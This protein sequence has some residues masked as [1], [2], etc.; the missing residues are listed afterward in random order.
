MNSGR[1]SVE[2]GYKHEGVA[3]E[4]SPE[5]RLDG[6]NRGGKTLVVYYSRS[7]NTRM[8]A[9]AISKRLGCDL[10]EITEPKNRGGLLGYMGAGSEGRKESI[11][12]INPTKRDLANYNIVIVGTP[13]WAWN[14]SSPIRSYLTLN[15]GKFP[16][17][18]FYVTLDGRPGDS[19]K[20]METLVGKTPLTSELFYSSEI[21][22]G[23]IQD[24]V[25][26]FSDKILTHVSQELKGIV[27][28]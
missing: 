28:R 5:E 18:A 22:K 4:Q 2:N 1:T 24:K 3:F 21:K 19:L 25:E 8:V 13:I 6:T 17:V 16:D 23:G 14:I 11:T 10:E 9:E 7:G 15:K 26:N 27:A 12:E 20:N